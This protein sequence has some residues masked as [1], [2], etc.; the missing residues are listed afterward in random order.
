MLSKPGGPYYKCTMS[1]I[2]KS[3]LHALL[4]FSPPTQPMYY[5]I[6]AMADNKMKKTKEKKN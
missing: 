1:F 3:H 4:F 2:L 5:M 6:F